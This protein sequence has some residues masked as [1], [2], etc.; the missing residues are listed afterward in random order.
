MDYK[1]LKRLIGLLKVDEDLTSYAESKLLHFI[2]K[3][4][5][6]QC[7]INGVSSRWFKLIKILV[8]GIGT[9]IGTYIIAVYL[10]NG[11]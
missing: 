2:N 7:N 9:G 5:T 4:E 3:Q 11:F 8:Y 1:E 10:N 6:K